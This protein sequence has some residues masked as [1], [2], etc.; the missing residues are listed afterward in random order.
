[1]SRTYRRNSEPTPWW[2]D[3]YPDKR[4]NISKW[5]YH[6]DKKMSHVHKK[7]LK[8]HTNYTRRKDERM[9]LSKVYGLEDYE[10]FDFVDYE[11]YY[12]GFIWCW[13]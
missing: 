2:V 10:D 11:K 9:Q 3:R 8:W 12:L 5:E 1:M 13:D 6:S 4:W 7:S